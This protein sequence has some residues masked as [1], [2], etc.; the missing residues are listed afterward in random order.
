MNAFS[1]PSENAPRSI[2]GRVAF[3][4]L[5]PTIRIEL[6]QGWSMVAIYERYASRLGVSYS[7][8]ARYVSANIR[9]KAVTPRSNKRDK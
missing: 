7:Q 3:L 2:P 5:L 1:A 4:A 8:F 9:G 6:E